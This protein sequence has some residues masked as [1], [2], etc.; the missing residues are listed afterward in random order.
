MTVKYQKII[1]I[2]MAFGLEV[3]SCYCLIHSIILYE[4]SSYR[5]WN[6]EEKST[7]IMELVKELIHLLQGTKLLK[8]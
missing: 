4:T 2:K 7:I 1:M 3:K 6:H 8:E 5:V